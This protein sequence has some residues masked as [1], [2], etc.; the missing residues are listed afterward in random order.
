MQEYL[1]ELIAA[2]VPIVQQAEVTDD[3][4]FSVFAAP[5]SGDLRSRPSGV[6]PDESS[7]TAPRPKRFY[8][9]MRLRGRY[10]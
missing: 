3:A 6:P 8:S 7:D 10:I 9:R 1:D 5:S 4:R 2:G